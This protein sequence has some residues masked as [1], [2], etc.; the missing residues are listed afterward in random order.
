MILSTN[1][2]VVSEQIGAFAE[3]EQ[4]LE[5][6]ARLSNKS[7]IDESNKAAADISGIYKRNK[8]IVDLGDQFITGLDNA[9]DTAKI[10]LA[11]SGFLLNLKAMSAGSTATIDPLLK[12]FQK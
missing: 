9:A 8:S 5:S 6:I 1:S 2:N 12:R 3:N 11:L 4:V 7:K 10:K